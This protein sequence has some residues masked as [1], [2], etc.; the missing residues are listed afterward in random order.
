MVADRH[1]EVVNGVGVREQADLATDGS[2]F[3]LLV[4]EILGEFALHFLLLSTSSR[5]TT[6]SVPRHQRRSPVVS[7]ALRRIFF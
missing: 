6:A 1:H 5:Q 2:I 3:F 7:A 4:M